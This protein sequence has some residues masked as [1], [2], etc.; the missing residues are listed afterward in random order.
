MARE[1]VMPVAVLQSFALKSE[2]ATQEQHSTKVRHK[3]HKRISR[4]PFCACC[5]FLW[6]HFFFEASSRFCSS[7]NRF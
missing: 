6:P 3:E 1:K 5:A 4:S 2:Q 7:L